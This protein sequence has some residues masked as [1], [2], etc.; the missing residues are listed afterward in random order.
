MAGMARG[1]A[2]RLR[3]GCQTRAYGSPIRDRDKLLAVLED[4]AGLGYEGFETNFASL[5]HSFADPAP[6]RNQIEKRRIELIGLHLGVGFFDPARF[7]QEQARIAEVARAV[8]ALGGTHLMLSG[9]QPPASSGGWDAGK[10]ARKC[11]QLDR[12]GRACRALGVRLCSHN[13][14][15]ELE[16]G[17]AH[18][19]ALLE[20]TDPRE[21]SFVL[22]VGNVFPPEF[23]ALHIARRYGSRLAA[24][25][26]RDTARGKEV[27][28]G[29]G[30]FDFAA[31]GRALGETRWAGWLIVEMNP[32]QDIP[33]RRMVEAARDYLRKT[34]Q[35]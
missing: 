14:T 28:M 5:E 19:K 18:L 4:L 25:H 17:G 20:G 34:M 8:Q 11:E 16:Q 10:L 21:V 23:S 32:R 13:H 2:G 6:M 22:D 30:G 33:S 12:A 29:S 7:E 3:L 31:L 35:I 9:N 15:H 26:L 1:A 24:F 27:L